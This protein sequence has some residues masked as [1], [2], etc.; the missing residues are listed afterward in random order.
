[1]GVILLI[2]SA[3]TSSP[4]LPTPAEAAEA[5]RILAFLES[6]DDSTLLRAFA[7][8]DAHA[9]VRL[10]HIAQQF[11]MR[12]RA[13]VTRTVRQNA[14]GDAVITAQAETGSFAAGLTDHV[15]AS[16]AVGPWAQHI[17]DPH[18]PH[19]NTRFAEDFIYRVLS[20]TV[21]WNRPVQVLSVEARTHAAQPLRKARYYVDQGT[22][23]GIYM[24]H[25]RRT[26]F[27]VEDTRYYLQVRPGPQGRWVPHHIHA[28][29]QL[30]F[31]LRSARRL[32]RSTTLFAH[33]ESASI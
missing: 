7:Q 17:V 11:G 8:A 10:S 13:T 9:H 24:E 16:L 4:A 26:L 14:P 19:R 23:T 2:Q 27:F 28:S 12:P 25:A 32:S 22:I 20:D 29:T 31:P 18:P 6:A 30:L 21:M 3:C 5:E 1:M 15:P 33:R